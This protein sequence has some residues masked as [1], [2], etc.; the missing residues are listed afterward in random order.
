MQ[1]LFTIVTTIQGPSGED[2]TVGQRGEPGE[3]VTI[4][5]LHTWHISLRE[6][7]SKTIEM[8]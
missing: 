1:T 8:C 5:S 3:Q 7:S 6:H 2:G 4:I